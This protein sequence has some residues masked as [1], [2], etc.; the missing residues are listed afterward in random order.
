MKVLLV[1]AALA[2]F[3]AVNGGPMELAEKILRVI[4]KCSRH[5]QLKFQ[6][7][8]AALRHGQLPTSDEGKCFVTCSLE[9]FGLIKDKKFSV[10]GSYALNEM[11]FSNPNDLQKANEVTKLCEKEVSGE[12]ENV[13]ELGIAVANCGLKNSR[14]E[15]IISSEL[16]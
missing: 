2:S 1:L 6:D 5:H 10:E 8:Q 15:G 7:V 13:C 3:S 16:W 11:R 14:S 9:E 4:R 12:Y